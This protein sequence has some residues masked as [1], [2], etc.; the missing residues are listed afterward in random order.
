[1]YFSKVIIS[2]RKKILDK[3]CQK[4]KIKNFFYFW[5]ELYCKYTQ[6]RQNSYFV[7]IN[8]ELYRKKI[9]VFA[10]KNHHLMF[11]SKNEK[12]NMRINKMAAKK[13][14]TLL[15][16]TN[17][18][19]NSL[20]IRCSFSFF[21]LHYSIFTYNIFIFILIWKFSHMSARTCQSHAYICVSLMYTKYMNHT[22]QQQ[23]S[24]AIFVCTQKKVCVRRVV[25]WIWLF[26]P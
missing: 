14:Q 15:F 12:M 4:N 22:K 7:S 26:A 11:T 6:H 25:T 24:R 1:M 10:D 23:T 3:K 18:G 8:F 9:L 19:Y 2:H 17:L 13:S 5:T 16:Y 21:Y 20:G